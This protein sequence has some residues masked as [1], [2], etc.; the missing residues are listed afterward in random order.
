METTAFPPVHAL[1]Q[2][3]MGIDY[4][5][6]LNT[7]M[8][9]IETIVLYVLAITQVFYQKGS[10][11]WQNGGQ[12]LT[13]ETIKKVSN[14]LSVSYI[15]VRSEGYPKLKQISKDCLANL[16]YQVEDLMGLI[17]TNYQ[18]WQNLMAV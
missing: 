8:N 9:I 5:K 18:N 2:F 15:W 16:T 13:L 6:H 10:D 17:V 11:W 3:L 7:Y 4:K 14:I 1:V 12:D